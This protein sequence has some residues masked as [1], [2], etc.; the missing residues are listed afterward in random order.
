VIVF[1]FAAL[2]NG[3]YL[4]RGTVVCIRAPSVPTRALILRGGGATAASLE[5][6]GDDGLSG[7]F[8]EPA[9]FF[10]P[11]PPPGRAS[12][13]RRESSGGGTVELV[14]S[15]RSPLWVRRENRE[16]KPCWG[17]T[18]A[19]CGMFSNTR[20]IACTILHAGCALIC[21]GRGKR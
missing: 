6:D 8:Q 20:R 12:Y 18:C 10:Q 14:T 1:V 4:D 3:G 17:L 2:F 11:P 7:L 15:G 5:G 9:D 19:K 13:C 21:V 16:E